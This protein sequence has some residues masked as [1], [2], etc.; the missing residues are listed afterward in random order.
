MKFNEDLLRL[1]PFYLSLPGKTL[2][3][4]TRGLAEDKSKRFGLI[5]YRKRKNNQ[6]IQYVLNKIHFK[7]LPGW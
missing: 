5:S 1:T 2:F 3:K 4:L 6:N 7:G